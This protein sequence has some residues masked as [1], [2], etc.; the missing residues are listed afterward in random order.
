MIL[1]KI[2]FTNQNFCVSKMK[3]LQKSIK[4]Q[5][6]KLRYTKKQKKNI[7]IKKEQYKFTFV[8]ESKITFCLVVHL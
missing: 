7:K 6:E 3:G 1:K 4:R 8:V 2:C 5:T